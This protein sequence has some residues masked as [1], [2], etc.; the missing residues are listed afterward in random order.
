[1]RIG[2]RSADVAA[3]EERAMPGRKSKR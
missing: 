3:I 2:V 1:M